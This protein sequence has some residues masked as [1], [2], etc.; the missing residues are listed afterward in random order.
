ME[1]IPAF[2][3]YAGR[4]RPA[5]PARPA[6]PQRRLG[7]RGISWEDLDFVA[8]SYVPAHRELL[9]QFRAAAGASAR[10]PCRAT[11]GCR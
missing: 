3:G 8:R 11:R 9:L 2:R 4:H 6:R 1:R 5:D 7:A 10:T